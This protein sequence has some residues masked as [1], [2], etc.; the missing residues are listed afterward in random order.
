VWTLERIAGKPGKLTSFMT[1]RIPSRRDIENRARKPWVSEAEPGRERTEGLDELFEAAVQR[2][3][4]LLRAAQAYLDGRMDEG[5]LSDI[6]GNIR[7]DLGI[8][9]DS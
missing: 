6:V 9:G 1:P 4:A 8:T 5:S 7:Y 2:A 3:A